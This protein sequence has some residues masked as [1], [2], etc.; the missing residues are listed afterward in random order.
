MEESEALERLSAV[1][2]RAEFQVAGARNFWEQ[3]VEAASRL[4][5]DMVLRMAS[6]ILKAAVGEGG[7]MG[8]A[9][10]GV[11]FALV[12]VLTVG[13]VRAIRL[14]VVRDSGEAARA[15]AARRE[16]ADRLWREGH[17]LARQ[18]QFGEAVRALYLSA[19]Y[20]LEERDV[21]EVRESFTN[22]EHALRV[23]EAMGRDGSEAFGRLVQR[24]DRVRYGHYAADDETFAEVRGL[25]ESTRGAR[26]ASGAMP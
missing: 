6:A 23:R 2:A 15:A 4:L 10:L 7:L 3:I 8:Y 17:E 21:L 26:L 22:R 1:L 11:S 18:G 12:V 25:V 5:E 14:S 16:R 24:F 19:L 20:S 9:V 13:F